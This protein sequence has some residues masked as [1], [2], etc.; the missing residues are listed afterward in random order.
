MKKGSKRS[1]VA[2]RKC[3]LKKREKVPHLVKHN[4]QGI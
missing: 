3:K 2:E 4:A 1:I